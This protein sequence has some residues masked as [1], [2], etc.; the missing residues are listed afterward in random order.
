MYFKQS[1]VVIRDHFR[2][3]EYA[4][5]HIYALGIKSRWGLVKIEGLIDY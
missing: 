5:F 2:L 4:F 1:E 3:G